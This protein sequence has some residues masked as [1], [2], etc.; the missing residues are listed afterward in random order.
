M[1]LFGGGNKRFIRRGGQKQRKYTPG[2][3]Q[4]MP[5]VLKIIKGDNKA[6]NDVYKPFSDILRS[7][8][9]VEVRVCKASVK[10]WYKTEKIIAPY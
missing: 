1:Y 8:D 5:L 3:A 9:A 4:D 7:I 10:A 6:Q 2:S